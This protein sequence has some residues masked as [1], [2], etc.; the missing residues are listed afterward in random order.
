MKDIRALIFDFGGTLDGNGIHWLERAYH[1]IHERH[2]EI[3]REAF[4]KADK[5]T[6]TEFALGDTSHEWSYQDGSMLPVGAVASEYAARCNLRETT[7]AIAVGIYKRLGLSDQMKDEYVDW[8]CAGAAEH[9]ENNRRWLE[10]LHGTYQLAVISNNFGNTRGWCDEYGLTPLLEVIIDSTVLGIAKPDARIFEAALSE[11]GVVPA[12]AIYV[13]DSYA[14]DMVGGKNA[15]L[16]TAWLVGNEE[17]AC[18]DLSM[19]D[20]QLSHLHELTDFLASV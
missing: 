9:L 7:D 19:V 12:H 16:W 13:G 10:T 4:D 6:I 2:P 18:P 14:A 15:G 20:V 17:K 5:E 3:T 1:F 8:F 11:L